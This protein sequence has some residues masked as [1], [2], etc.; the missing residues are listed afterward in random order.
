M[1][2]RGGSLVVHKLNYYTDICSGNK[3]DFSCSFT[4]SKQS[5]TVSATPSLVARAHGK[6][7]DAAAKAL[8]V[9]EQVQVARRIAGKWEQLSLLLAPELFTLEKITQIRRQHDDLIIRAQAMIDLWCR[10]YHS[11]A[12]RG[13]LI[14][15]LCNMSERTIA[16]EV[17]GTDLV[18]SVH[19]L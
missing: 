1:L 19:S 5:E 4:G 2:D 7:H 9:R 13:S 16:V 11:K 3:D 14:L 17:F 18:H 12:T 10:H 8:D 6:L 15:A